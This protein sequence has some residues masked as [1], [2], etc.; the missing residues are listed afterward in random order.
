MS[1]SPAL[2]ENQLNLPDATL[3]WTRE[4]NTTGPTLVW[5]HGLMSNSYS[6]EDKGIYDFTPI[7]KAGTLIRYDARG[8]GRS[9]A[10]PVPQRF[11]WPALADDFLAVA[12]IAAP[13]EKIIGMGCSMGT[14][15]LLHA[16]LKAPTTFSKLVLTAPPTAWETRRAHAMVYNKS[17]RALERDGQAALDALVANMAP[18]PIFT[19]LPAF[20]VETGLDVLPAILRGAGMSNLPARDDLKSISVP[21]LILAWESDPSHPIATAHAL[22]DLLPNTELHVAKSVN[23]V[24]DWGHRIA[25]F[26]QQPT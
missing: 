16:A 6:L 5:A 24:R 23:D 3:V 2:H 20:P 17:A 1:A 21:V 19:D 9:N 7:S 11:T 18:P 4:G 26:M 25:D 22:A 8:H 10:R 15:T 14:A 13:N 12:K